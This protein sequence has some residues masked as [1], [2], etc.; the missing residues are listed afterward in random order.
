[1]KIFYKIIFISLCIICLRFHP[2]FP[3]QS[4]ANQSAIQQDKK[5]TSSETKLIGMKLNEENPLLIDFYVY[6]KIWDP[7]NSKDKDYQ[8]LIDFFLVS[9]SSP[10]NELWVNLSP[11]EENRI[12]PEFLSKT[13]MG[14]ILLEQDS[15]LKELSA[16]LLNPESEP[17]EL[18]WDEL[19][20]LSESP[21]EAQSIQ[22]NSYHKIWILPDRVRIIESNSQVIILESY[23]KIMLEDDY[24]ALKKNE[25]NNTKSIESESAKIYREIVIPYVE[26]E[27]NHGEKFAPLRKIF[28][29][30][31]LAAWYKKTLNKSLITKIYADKKKEE[32]LNFTNPS[33]IEKIYQAYKKSFTH[34]VINTMREEYDPQSG[35]IIP[36]KYFTG[37]INGENVTFDNTASDKGMLTTNLRIK[38]KDGTIKTA[39]YLLA[40]SDVANSLHRTTKKKKSFLLG[41]PLLALLGCDGASNIDNAS[42]ADYSPESISISAMETPAVGKGSIRNYPNNSSVPH[43]LRFFEDLLESGESH[44]REGRITYE[45]NKAS[46]IVNRFSEVSLGL[47][48]GPTFRYALDPHVTQAWKSRQSIYVYSK[49]WQ[50]EAEITSDPRFD[51]I[52]RGKGQLIIKTPHGY[53]QI[54]GYHYGENMV[55]VSATVRDIPLS[56]DSAQVDTLYQQGKNLRDARR[57]QEALDLYTSSELRN[58]PKIYNG[59]I[60]VHAEIGDFEEALRLLDVHPYVTVSDRLIAYYNLGAQYTGRG[61]LDPAYHYLKLAA[62]TNN[63]LAVQLLR[64]VEQRLRKVKRNNQN[65]KFRSA[66]VESLYAQGLVLRSRGL[67]Y[68]AIALFENSPLK[69]H[70]KILNGLIAAYAENGDMDK[71]FD[72]L[73]THP[74]S[75]Q[76]KALAYY[77][78]AN[79]LFILKDIKHPALLYAQKAF[80]SAGNNADL[81]RNSSALQ[82]KIRSH[83]P[84]LLPGPEHQPTSSYGHGDRVMT[85]EKEKLGGI[86]LNPLYLNY[87]STIES[88]INPIFNISPIKVQNIHIRGLFPIPINKTPTTLLEFPFLKV[89]SSSKND[90]VYQLSRM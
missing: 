40:S 82:D 37:G 5:L 72:L 47:K 31:I 25:V 55:N 24:L 36:R 22:I 1:M 2:T 56:F 6:S 90:F 86:D 11:Y 28:H 48:N 53:V 66:D 80:N 50:K 43:A 35:S 34:G 41:L 89:E 68:E 65:W 27:I 69:A 62:Q 19:H 44:G 10:P 39:R 51:L 16:T 70:T 81:I 77:G 20:R 85:S 23:L 15:Q 46:D 84:Y 59:I 64:T 7:T 4:L 88:K 38:I 32:G 3:I 8:E 18:Y 49:V 78:I 45:T 33:N 14:Q 60:S 52:V 79:A 54:F 67:P 71:A 75:D 57:Y 58:T 13:N 21:K 26:K 29:S 42:N 76:E 61:L 74:G 63:P 87:K 73:S 30:L 83:S 17:G 9:L 12:I